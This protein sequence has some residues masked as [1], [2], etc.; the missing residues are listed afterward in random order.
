MAQFM[1]ILHDNPA[2]WAQVAPSEIQRIIGEYVAWR[3][4][5]EARGR[6]VSSAKLTDDGGKSLAKAGGQIRVVDGPYAEAKEVVGGYFIV[7]ADG[8]DDAVAL[9]RDCPHLT[10]DRI[11][12][13]Q[14][15]RV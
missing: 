3:K 9:C 14:L 1:L 13:R 2:A 4:G 7:E 11:E 12:V 10:Y 6:F 15:D 8:Y 5:L